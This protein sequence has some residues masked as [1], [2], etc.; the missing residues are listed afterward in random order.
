[1]FYL[2]DY[3]SN[4]IIAIPTKLITNKGFLHVFQDLHENLTTQGLKPSYMLLENKLSPVFQS[5]LKEKCIDY[6]L[7][8]PGIHQHYAA[9]RDIGNFK[10]HFIMGLCLNDTNLPTQNWDILFEKEKMTL[11]IL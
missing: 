8:P 2:Y 4:S 10:E 6:Q 7:V 1:M 5:I 9:E 3:K 11:N